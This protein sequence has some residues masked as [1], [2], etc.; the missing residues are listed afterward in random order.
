[1]VGD[2]DVPWIPDEVEDTSVARVEDAMGL[3]Q[4]RALL[5]AEGLIGAAFE[6]HVTPRVVANVVGSSGLARL[7]SM[8]AI[9]VL[10]ERW[11]EAMTRSSGKTVAFR[12]P[13]SGSREIPASMTRPAD[14]RSD[15]TRAES[16]RVSRPVFPGD[17]RGTRSADS[18]ESLT[19]PGSGWRS[20]SNVVRPR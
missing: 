1:V 7:V 10:P 19:L 6:E 16:N 9:H 14:R 2:G 11:K 4:S 13:L 18:A 17:P 5:S 8:N 20:D 12:P 15:P 3:D